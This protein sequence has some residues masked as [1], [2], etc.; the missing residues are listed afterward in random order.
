MNKGSKADKLHSR[1]AFIFAGFLVCVAVAIISGLI[2]FDNQSRPSA[3][4]NAPETYED[5]FVEVDW[6]YWKSVNPD[7]IGWVNVEG[8][9]INYPIVA[10]HADDPNF[11]LKHDIY[12]KY[13]PYGVPYLDADC[14]GNID[15]QNAVVYGHHMNND[16]MF[17]DFANFRDPAYI[18]E[19]APIYLQ[20]PDKKMKLDVKYVDVI[21]ANQGG[22]YTKFDDLTSF[23]AWYQDQLD[24]ATLVVDKYAQPTH[25][26]NFCTCSYG[27]FRNERTLVCAADPASPHILVANPDQPKEVT[28]DQAA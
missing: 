8:T 27:T 4:P 19:H 18:E 6:D 28:N 1:F 20:T 3:T 12:G 16:T 2:Y 5:G 26:I 13:N 25:V 9:Q 11:Y 10:A 15:A 14:E 22:K 21:N 24:K 17:S 7:I 23:V